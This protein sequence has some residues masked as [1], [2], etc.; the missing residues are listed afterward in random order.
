MCEGL[1]ISES[2]ASEFLLPKNW[3][4]HIFKIFEIGLFIRAVVKAIISSSVLLIA[5][6]TD[7]NCASP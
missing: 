7:W 4:Q 2:D 1:V 3:F 5:E 6:D